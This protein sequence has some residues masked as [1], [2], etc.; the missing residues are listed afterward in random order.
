MGVS[1]KMF[2]AEVL[3]WFSHSIFSSRVALSAGNDIE[4]FCNFHA[5]LF[6]RPSDP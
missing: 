3:V 1:E 4:M 5:S 6:Y 2:T